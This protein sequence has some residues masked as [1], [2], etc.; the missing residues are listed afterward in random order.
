MMNTRDFRCTRQ[1]RGIHDEQT[2]SK[3]LS[4]D[5][6]TEENIYRILLSSIIG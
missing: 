5:L 3:K 2:R 6:L 1:T 4:H